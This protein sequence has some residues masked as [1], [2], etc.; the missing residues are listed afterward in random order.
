MSEQA[1]CVIDGGKHPSVQ[2]KVTGVGKYPYLRLSEPTVD[3]GDV[4][5]GHTVEKQLRL[6]NQSIV[7]ASYAIERVEEQHDHVYH[8][9]PSKGTLAPDAYETIRVAYTVRALCK[10][11]HNSFAS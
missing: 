10:L 2:T 8:V 11:E 6:F 1:C 4:L 7:G 5:V 3:F 9:G